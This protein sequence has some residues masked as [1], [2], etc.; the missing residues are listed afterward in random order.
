MSPDGVYVISA[1]LAGDETNCNTAYFP[2]R[3][4]PTCKLTHK[5]V[6]LLEFV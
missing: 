2:K 4:R 6:Y 1:G 3:N 5:V